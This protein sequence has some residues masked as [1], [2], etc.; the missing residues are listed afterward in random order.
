MNT[1]N[2][3]SI[4]NLELL[5]VKAKI[6]TYRGRSALQVLESDVTNDDHS[7]AILP[8]SMFKDGVIETE[9]AGSLRAN[10]PQ[11][12][13]GFVGIAFHVQTQGSHFECFYL[14]PTNGR[15]ED[16]LRRNHATQYISHPDHPW[17][18]LREENPGVYESYIDL[19][20]DEWTKIKIAVKGVHA[21]LF[22]NGAEQPCL[23][24]NDLK[25]GEAQGQ[26]GLWIGAGTEAHF[27]EIS[28][29]PLA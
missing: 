26:I 29:T 1:F 19:L 16:Q 6:V 25:L 12:M 21:Q 20:P 27:S 11:A 18:K 14:R 28:V 17:F 2:L 4:S 9:I 5:N 3:N 13:R 24:V 22:V 15:A 7:I 8:D 23:I 10:A